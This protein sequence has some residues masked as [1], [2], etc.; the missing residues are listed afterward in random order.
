VNPADHEA[1][2]V[3][4]QLGTG[5]HL[6]RVEMDRK[7]VSPLRVVTRALQALPTRYR[8]AWEAVQAVPWP[9]AGGSAADVARWMLVQRWA[10]PR[11]TAR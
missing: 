9:K 7:G 3:L 1:W 4:F 8:G 5:A 11:K 10:S 2:A 6:I